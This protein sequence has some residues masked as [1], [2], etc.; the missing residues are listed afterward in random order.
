MDIFC[1]VKR[2][3]VRRRSN[4][5][6]PILPLDR[7]LGSAYPRPDFSSREILSSESSSSNSKKSLHWTLTKE[8]ESARNAESSMPMS[9]QRSTVPPRPPLPEH[10]FVDTGSSSSSED[11][12][13]TST[14]IDRFIGEMKR[15][16]SDMPFAPSPLGDAAQ[17]SKSPNT[18]Q[19][20]RPALS[21]SQSTPARK[22]MAVRF[23][24]R[25]EDS[26][27]ANSSADSDRELVVEDGS[28]KSKTPSGSSFSAEEDDMAKRK[29]E[30]S[31]EDKRAARGKQLRTLKSAPV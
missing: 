22:L 30:A 29:V 12:V 23:S 5:C 2:N 27:D 9:R 3:Q 17:Y 14:P 15:M 31:M 18:R 11:E 21:R 13:D 7:E 25:E 10:L 8:E 28:D 20:A 4:L 24:D 26:T 6:G 16:V 19:P 1:C